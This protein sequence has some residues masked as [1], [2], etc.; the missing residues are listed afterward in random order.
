MKS[1]SRLLAIT[2]ME[3]RQMRRERLTFGM[4][5]GIPVIQMLLFGYAFNTDVRKLRT[6]IADH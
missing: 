5:V 6:A 3:V 4:F 2:K 1:L